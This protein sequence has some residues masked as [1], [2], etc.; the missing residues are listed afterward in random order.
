[1]RDPTQLPKRGPVGCFALLSAISDALDMPEPATKGD[2]AYLALLAARAG[3]VVAAIRHAMREPC[4]QPAMTAIAGLPRT[5][6]GDVD[7]STL[8][9]LTTPA[10]PAAANGKDGG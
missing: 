2:E 1:M 7:L 3:V 8:Y 9:D 6:I 4:D 5:Q 10:P